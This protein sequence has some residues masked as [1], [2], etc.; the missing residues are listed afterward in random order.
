MRHSCARPENSCVICHVWRRS[1]WHELEQAGRQLLGR[2][3]HRKDY[4][5]GEVVFAQGEQN[6]GVHCVSGGTV[7]IRRL[8]DNGNSVLLE[9]AY[10]G[11][12]IGYRSFLTGSEHKTSA[13][14]LGPSVVCH[15]DRATIPACLPATRRL[16]CVFSNARS[17]NSNTRTT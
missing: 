10:P 17:A 16:A 11:D 9:L 1:D 2:G 7:G 8:D 6:N 3:R 15:I 13:E 14:A 4:N 5:S 12:T